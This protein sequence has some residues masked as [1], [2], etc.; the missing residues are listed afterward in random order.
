MRLERNSVEKSAVSQQ[1]KEVFSAARS[2]GEQSS[3][4]SDYVK[5]FESQL[6]G[7]PGKIETCVSSTDGSVSLALVRGGND[8]SLLT[9]RPEDKD[10][11]FITQAPIGLKASAAQLF[12]ALLS[13]F[14]EQ[15]RHEAAQVQQ[16]LDVNADLI[17][18]WKEERNEIPF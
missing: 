7:F 18:Q 6:S 9:S 8:W 10:P 4:L 14:Q 1:L 3:E 17:K 15:I 13:K 11:F 16:A 5:W 2:F 12:P